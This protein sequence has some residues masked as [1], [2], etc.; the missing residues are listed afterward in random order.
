MNRETE[1]VINE[2]SA[3]GDFQHARRLLEA[4]TSRKCEKFPRARKCNLT[5]VFASWQD[6]DRFG[7]AGEIPVYFID[8]KEAR[9]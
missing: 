2:H 1:L 9:P 4:R 6:E 8:M 5:W 7:N 3:S